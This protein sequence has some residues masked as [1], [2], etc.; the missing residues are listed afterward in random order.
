MEKR[1]EEGGVRGNIE[2]L[3]LF[4]C[5]YRKEVAAGKSFWLWGRCAAV[6]K[7]GQEV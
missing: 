5:S 7:E 2:I 3:L 1:A 4:E 6:V